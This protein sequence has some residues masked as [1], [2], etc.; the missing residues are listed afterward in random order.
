MSAYPAELEER[1]RLAGGAEIFLRP[2]RP[3]DGPLLQ[4]LLDHM[5]PQD[6]RLRFFAPIRRLPEALV[7]Q[8]TEVDY[9]TRIALLAF[10]ADSGAILGVVRL[11]AEPD[12][13]RAEFAVAL[14]S[15]W[16][17]HGLGWLLMH[18]MLALAARMGVGEVFGYVLRTNE[19]MLD[20]CREMGFSVEAA[21]GE[22][23][24]VLVRRAVAATP[25]PDPLPAGA[26]REGEGPASGGSG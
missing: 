13:N 21:P 24:A 12:G 3:E 10:A 20:M 7:R 11:S 23:E 6:R 4:D 2:I 17:G 18:R 9:K 26:E 5:S 19:T 16:H 25:G 15:D 1:T 14:R 8:L 22:G